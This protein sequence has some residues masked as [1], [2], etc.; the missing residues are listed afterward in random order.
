MVFGA[1]DGHEDDVVFAA[2][3]DDFDSGCVLYVGA[4]FANFGFAWFSYS[5]GIASISSW[6]ASQICFFN[7]PLR[8]VFKF[9]GR[10]VG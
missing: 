7:L 10:I 4:C 9:N 8:V 6:L 1:A 2:L 5:L 3:F